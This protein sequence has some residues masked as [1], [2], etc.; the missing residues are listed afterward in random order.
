MPAQQRWLLQVGCLAIVVGAAADSPYLPR[1][2]PPALRF[3]SPRVD[4]PVLQ[5]P[6]LPLPP[7]D[8]KPVTTILPSVP[9]GSP[10][11]AGVPLGATSNAVPSAV[12]VEPFEPV[13]ASSVSLPLVAQPEPA[14]TAAEALT[15]QMFMKFFTGKPGTNASGTS[16]TLY[17][18]LP[19]IPPIPQTTPSSTATFQTTPP[20]SPPKP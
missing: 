18:P 9:D 7:L 3:E 4:T 19:F 5:S 15:P 11:A 12:V 17:A 2:G 1:V 6:L 13:G 14:P 20:P 10:L 8:S 16:T